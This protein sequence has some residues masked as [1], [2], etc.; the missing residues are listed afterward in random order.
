MPAH[1]HRDQR[2]APGRWHRAALEEQVRQGVRGPAVS[3]Q[4]DLR[5]ALPR[6]HG[7][8]GRNARPRDFLVAVIDAQVPPRD[9]S[10]REQDARCRGVC[11]QALPCR[12]AHRLVWRDAQLCYPAGT[13]ASCTDPRPQ[14]RHCRRAWRGH[15]RVPQRLRAGCGPCELGAGFGA[16]HSARS[17]LACV[18]WQ[19]QLRLS[20]AFSL[21]EESKESIGILDYSLSQASLEQARGPPS[22]HRLRVCQGQVPSDG[23]RISY[24][25]RS[26]S[27]HGYLPC[28]RHGILPA[29]RR[30]SCGSRR[31]KSTRRRTRRPTCISSLPSKHRG[32]TTPPDGRQTDGRLYRVTLLC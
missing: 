3:V 12:H 21:L 16:Q 17:G 4:A 32:R 13:A 1:R 2:L 15:A 28:C 29:R 6:R 31:T 22:C 18:P 8:P 27:L 20:E 9:Q 23:T 10:T 5:R 7:S 24:S 19:G 26:V 30:C 14:P 11:R 25:Q